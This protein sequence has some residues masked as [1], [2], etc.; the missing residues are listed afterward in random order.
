MQRFDRR[1][2]MINEEEKSV[3]KQ[4]FGLDEG[5]LKL[6]ACGACVENNGL[7]K[8]K[9]K[10]FSVLKKPSERTGQGWI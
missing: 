4:K 7:L 9:K 1:T 6:A 2:G 10:K 8:K 5:Y 3:P